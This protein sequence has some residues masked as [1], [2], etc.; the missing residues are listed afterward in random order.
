MPAVFLRGSM[1]KV[2]MLMKIKKKTSITLLTHY[3][4]IFESTQQ[5][6][7][8]QAEVRGRTGSEL[9]NGQ[10]NSDYAT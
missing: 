8:D 3:S 7:T 6:D 9:Q 10:D 4:V 2:T 1:I 5:K